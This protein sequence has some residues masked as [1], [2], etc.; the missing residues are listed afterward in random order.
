MLPQR[1]GYIE[2]VAHQNYRHSQGVI[3]SR[4][5]STMSSC[6]LLCFLLIIGL[7]ATAFAETSVSQ[8]VIG[9]RSDDG[10]NDFLQ[11]DGGLAFVG[12]TYSQN[13]GGRDA[14]IFVTDSS[15]IP[16]WSTTFGGGANESAIGVVQ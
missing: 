12:N 14:L 4:H 1:D 5:N 7:S 8:I 3:L 11:I 16:T 2:V 9:A 10:I 6:D 13:V 15:G